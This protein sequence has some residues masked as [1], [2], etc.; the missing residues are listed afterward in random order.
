MVDG[1]A[2][3]AAKSAAAPAST[4]A[5]LTSAEA[6]VRFTAAQLGVATHAANNYVEKVQLDSG[7]W[8]NKCRRD[9]Q[10]P[11]NKAGEKASTGKRE[12]AAPC[13]SSPSASTDD[14]S[15]EGEAPSFAKVP[16][17]PSRKTVRRRS[18]DR[19]VQRLAQLVAQTSGKLDYKLAKLQS[20]CPIKVE[21]LANSAAANQG[22]SEGRS[23]PSC[24]SQEPLRAPAIVLHK[25]FVV[26]AQPPATR[27]RPVRGG[28]SYLKGA[29]RLAVAALVTPTCPRAARARVTL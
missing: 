28:T 18:A 5:L 15:T 26:E 1:L 11:P 8:V 7:V 21:R 17:R 10:Q 16:A 22:G 2:K 23:Q 9:A 25:P 4:V 27:A 12:P 20:T 14:S 29:T 19:G 24:E 13:V 3:L 6:L